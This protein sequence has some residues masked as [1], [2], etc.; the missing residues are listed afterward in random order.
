VRWRWF[1][2]LIDSTHVE[3]GVAATTTAAFAQKQG[4]KDFPGGNN[5][6][7]QCD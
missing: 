2:R 1:V 7:L 3:R 4:Q 5:S 6:P